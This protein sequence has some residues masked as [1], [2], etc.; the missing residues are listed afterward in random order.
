[1]SRK[2]RY[3][4]KYSVLYLVFLATF[5]VKSRKIDYL[6]DSGE[7]A[8]PHFTGFESVTAAIKLH[9]IPYICTYFFTSGDWSPVQHGYSTIMILKFWKIQ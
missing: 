2:T 3:Y 6:W 5:Q 1:M 4:L 8:D 9:K 7:A